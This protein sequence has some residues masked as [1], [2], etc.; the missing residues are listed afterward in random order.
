MN[1]S[2]NI[3]IYLL[4]MC[5][6]QY[7]E[8]ESSLMDSSVLA[9]TQ[10]TERL[11]V[12]QRKKERKIWR[13]LT[14]WNTKQHCYTYYRLLDSDLLIVNQRVQQQIWD[15]VVETGLCKDVGTPASDYHYLVWLCVH[16][17]CRA[18]NVSKICCS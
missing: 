18:V 5:H 15:V 16:N 17:V 14:T 13:Y 4:I 7:D 2:F 3:F 1:R 11:Q 10:K 12:R 8:L 9:Q 6:L